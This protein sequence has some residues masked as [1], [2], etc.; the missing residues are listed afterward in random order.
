VCAHNE[1]VEMRNVSAFS[2][3]EGFAAPSSDVLHLDN[4]PAE[5]EAALP[6]V[7]DGVVG[8]MRFSGGVAKLDIAAGFYPAECRFESCRPRCFSGEAI[9]SG[10][11]DTFLAAA[12]R[13]A[14]DAR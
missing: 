1:H 12:L 9:R 11:A 14:W 13:G 6:P 8:W 3:I 10:R 5:V 7:R 2:R 4:D